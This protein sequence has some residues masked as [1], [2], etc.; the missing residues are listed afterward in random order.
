[1]KRLLRL[2]PTL[3]S[4]LFAARA[5][6]AGFEADLFHPT[7]TG[8]GYYAVDGAFPVRHLGYSAGLFGTWAHRPLVLR[9]ATG[10]VPDGGNVVSNQLA[11]D[12]VGSFGIFGRLELGLDLPI[13][14]YQV[15]DDRL[16]GVQG[17]LAS[18]QV[19]DLRV[20][21]KGLLYT[22][23][24][25][26]DHR[27][28]F[29]L[30]AGL[31]LPTGDQRS[32]LGQGGVSGRPRAVVE[33]RG[34]RASAGL[35]LGA[36]LRAT[37]QFADLTVGHQLSFGVAGRYLIGHGFEAL[38]ELAGLIGLGVPHGLSSAEAPLE[39]LGGGRWRSPLGFEVSLAGGAGLTRGYGTPD[40]RIVLG[41]RFQA[42][43][44][45]KRSVA[46]LPPPPPA[47]AD[48][49]GDGVLDSEDRCPHQRGPRLNDGCPEPDSDGDGVPDSRDRCPTIKGDAKNEGCPNDDRDH[50]GV[51]DKFDR[52]PDVPG[53]MDN[54]GCP[55]VDS[56]GDGIV[57]RLDKC[58]FDAEVFNGVLDDDGCP[59][60]PAAL[61]ELRNDRVAL[62]QQP[63]FDADDELDK[64]SFLLLNAA[65]KVLSLHPELT[66]IRVEGH[67]DNRGSAIENLD[68]SRARAAAVRRYLVEKRAIAP[69]RIT[70]QGYGP[71]RPIADNHSE[72]GR[73]RNRRV[74]IMIVERRD[75]PAPTP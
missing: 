37:R 68:H 62:L 12:V 9:D 32:F 20:D 71:D 73:A 74:E 60:K 27:L 54:D 42:P 67:T 55:D 3:L 49:D 30:I 23:R 44:R 59:D 1:M 43:E 31:T 58:P 18:T 36:V 19:G 34:S 10:R 46:S 17:G 52:C 25:G 7:D 21:I 72:T 14:L 57:D 33:W 15:T 64:K 35:S 48:S 66:K 50:D 4:L 16:A 65:A 51:P 69:E 24:L 38:L 26:A 41:F 13:S 39:I 70:A 53:S 56:D 6:A 61:V 45:A 22:I 40:G 63:V 2:G 5:G 28:G 75:L 47:P 29:T 8:E 11:A